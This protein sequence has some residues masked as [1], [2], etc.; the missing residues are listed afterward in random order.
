MTE[1]KTPAPAQV[2][3]QAPAKVEAKTAPVKAVPAKVEGKAPAKGTG[4]KAPAKAVAAPAEGK[5]AKAPAKV[6]EPVQVRP[7]KDVWARLATANNSS[8]TVNELLKKAG[9]SGW[10]VTRQPMAAL[11]PS[12]KCTDCDQVSGRKHTSGCL[13]LAEYPSDKGLVESDHTT[14]PVLAPGVWSLVMVDKAEEFGFRHIGH[15]TREANPVPIEVRSSILTDILKT[16]G[17]KTGPAGPLWDS[18]GAFA[19]VR[20]P[21]M[22][23]VGKVDTVEMRAV[24]VNSLVPGRGSVVR[25]MPVHTGTHTVLPVTL[26]DLSDRVELTPDDNSDTRL[27]EASEA[28][29]LFT[30]FAQGF[31]EIATKLLRK[32]MTVKEFE[33]F[34]DTVLKDK[35]QPSAGKAPWDLYSLR[36]GAAGALFRGEVDLTE[37]IK[38]TRW[39]ALL[40]VLCWAQTVKPVKPGTEDA[41]R[42]RDMAVLFPARESSNTAQA[43]LT[44]LSEGL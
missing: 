16:T 36:T 44:L 17:A 41:R 39:A 12:G 9:V 30:R 7:D 10:S 24:L 21:D 26:P 33:T 25:V 19:T 37:K 38:G 14:V 15:T 3:Q 1:P 28:L 8:R 31:G 11:V 18:T 6:E 27:S 5:P 4:G 13:M 29:D 32:K 22:V 43:A 35:P 23:P 40:A 20:V 34:A 42:A 2:A